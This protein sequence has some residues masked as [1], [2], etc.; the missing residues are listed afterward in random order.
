M[1]LWLVPLSRNILLLIFPTACFHLSLSAFV[2]RIESL[3][4]SPS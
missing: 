4:P 1:Y 3:L 2:Y